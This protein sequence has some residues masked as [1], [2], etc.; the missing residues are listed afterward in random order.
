MTIVDQVLFDLWLCLYFQFFDPFSCFF[1]N[2]QNGLLLPATLLL[3]LPSY[4]LSGT[5]GDGRVEGDTL[6]LNPDV[7]ETYQIDVLE[8]TSP[9]RTICEDGITGSGI[10]E[11]QSAITVDVDTALCEGQIF[12][13]LGISYAMPLESE[14]ILSLGG[15]CDT[16]FIVTLEF[17]TPPV[18]TV[19][20]D[21]CVSDG[22]FRGIKISADTM[23]TISSTG[24]GC[25]SMF[26]LTYSPSVLPDSTFRDELCDNDSRTINGVVYDVNNPTGVYFTVTAEG[27]ELAVFVDIDFETAIFKDLDTM[28]CEGTTVDIAGQIFDENNTDGQVVFPG[29]SATGCD[30]VVFVSLEFIE[31]EEVEVPVFLCPGETKTLFGIE[32]T[33][34]LTSDDLFFIG[35]RLCDTVL[36]FVVGMSEIFVEKIDTTICPSGSI[37]LFGETFDENRLSDD[38]MLTGSQGACDSIIQ[39]SLQVL[40][41]YNMD[42]EQ[43]FCTGQSLI[44]NNNT[45]DENNPIGVEN[46]IASNG[47]DSVVNISLSFGSLNAEV[48]AKD[49]CQETDDGQ[50][51]INGL[52]GQ[53]PYS[54]TVGE[55]NITF[56]DSFIE[57]NDLAPGDYDISIEDSDGCQYEDAV[58]I[59]RVDDFNLTVNSIDNGDGTLSLDLLSDVP[60]ISAD[61][62]PPLGLSCSNCTNPVASIT[63]DQSYTVTAF[64][65]NGCSG[66]LAFTLFG[67]VGE[68]NS[69]YLPTAFNPNSAANDRFFLQSEVGEVLS[70]T[71][72]IFNRW[73]EKVYEALDVPPNNNAFGWDG[74]R[75]GVQLNPGVFIY[76]IVMTTNQGTQIMETGDVLLMK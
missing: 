19:D 37:E 30:S 65:E 7:S 16:I 31:S 2:N 1:D 45:Y 26:N 6:F 36:S 55:Q 71:M 25:D 50:I 39:V 67:S 34:N 22:L 60:L 10:V 38:I 54:V 42:F 59:Q 4:Y 21:P 3:V 52:N 46:L 17:T 23:I 63:Q 70:Y 15:S 47:C 8:F 48:A 57:L 51:S 49:A 61:W 68:E 9:N 20:I 75:N 43:S 35:P 69:F 27:C 58:R 18:K 24:D 40:Q 73:G 44:I 64:D 32:V 29:A 13:F 5:E 62:V 41:T 28:V 12:E 14:S 56:D 33:E 66:V 53:A 72:H 76:R 74:R 11:F